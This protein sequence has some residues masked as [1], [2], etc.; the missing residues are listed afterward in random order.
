MPRHRPATTTTP[1]SSALVCSTAKRTR[2]AA[3]AAVPWAKQTTMVFSPSIFFFND[4]AT[5][6][7]YTLSL[8]DALPIFLPPE[9]GPILECRLK[10]SR[11]EN[12]CDAQRPPILGRLEARRHQ[13]NSYDNRLEN[14]CPGAS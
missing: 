2:A 12:L 9:A 7:I 14:Y 6:E 8:H 11:K 13:L 5:T 10:A 1:R 4:T 3:K